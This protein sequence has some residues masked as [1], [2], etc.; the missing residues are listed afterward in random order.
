[1]KTIFFTIVTTFLL[2]INAIGQEPT[3]DLTFTAIDSATYTKLDSIKVHNRTLGG[4][5]ML[6]WPDTTLVLD[7]QVGI[8]ESSQNSRTIQVFQNYPNPVTEHTNISLYI[9]QN[10]KVNIIIMD[11][12]GRV[13]LKY[14]R[15][16]NY[17]LHTFRFF[18]GRRNLY[19]FIA[20]YK[21]KSSSIKI[22]NSSYHQKRECYLEY[23][24]QKDISS[25]LKGTEDIQNFHFNL[26]DELLYIGY[27]DTLQSG[28]Q[29]NPED[30]ENY[31]F[32]FATNIPCPGMPTVEYEGQVYNTIQVFSQCW[33]KENLNVGLM[34]PGEQEMSDNDTIEKYCYNNN[35]NSCNTYG[36]LYQWN[37]IMKYTTQQGAQGICPQ[38]WHIP[39]DEEWKILEGTVDSQYGVGDPVW[40]HMEERGYDAG[41]NLKSTSGWN[42]VNNGTDL[43]GFTALP[44]GFRFTDGNFYYLGNYGYWCSSTEISGSYALRR[45]LYFNSDDVHR[46]HYWKTS[47][48]PLRCLK[49]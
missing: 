4:D 21:G 34:I 45:Y 17:G 11:V 37:E 32:Q 31:T 8:S 24:G 29:D 10:D 44:G 14:N 46:Y 18:P 39:N 12:L 23:I 35:A 41:K 48:F 9:P 6:H 3:L 49:D 16:L 42:S 40:D 2:I 26:G 30:N 28:I 36:G 47:G 7:Y 13:I 5:T 20:Q 19:F 38:G 33:I 1:M 15:I 22:M 43:Y 25:D 27:T